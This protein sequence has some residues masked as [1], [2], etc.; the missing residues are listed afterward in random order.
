MDTFIYSASFTILIWKPL[1]RIG[2]TRASI[3]SYKLFYTILLLA[4][5]TAM[6]EYH[7]LTHAQ[8]AV[9]QANEAKGSPIYIG[10]VGA[11]SND[12][13]RGMELEA[14]N[15][16][17]RLAFEHQ[18]KYK[19]GIRGQPIK[20]V[21]ANTTNGDP[22]NV[23]PRLQELHGQYYNITCL[24]GIVGESHSDEA[25]KWGAPRKITIVQPF[26]GVK[27]YFA[28]FS[29]GHINMFPSP[30]EALVTLIR[31]LVFNRQ[32][33][34]IALMIDMQK[35]DGSEILTEAKRLCLEVGA[36]FVYHL[37]VIPHASEVDTGSIAK[38]FATKPQAVISWLY[39]SKSAT[40]TIGTVIQLGG[41]DLV[42]AIRPWAIMMTGTVVGRLP[43]E[44]IGNRIVQSLMSPLPRDTRF[45]VVRQFHKEAALAENLK[46]YSNDPN[47]SILLDK[48]YFLGYLM[49]KFAIQLHL[50]MPIQTAEQLRETLFSN[51]IITVDDAL[52]GPFSKECIG[53]RDILCACHNGARAVYLGH[54]VKKDT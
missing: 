51:K 36:E 16:G 46:F 33:K 26:T 54:F 38:M 25:I 18:N 19:N 28:P 15:G 35:R 53:T 48:M 20:L 4:G 21:L 27:S 39:I 1:T 6:L 43:I 52:Y 10:S 7:P 41:P 14:L 23:I 13:L 47:K 30:N 24:I 29:I 34:R 5:Y 44:A 50:D 45:A 9:L 3:K 12:T 49:G 8:A 31:Y 11:Y 37:E 32:V 42:I 22:N 17:I 2:F 40:S